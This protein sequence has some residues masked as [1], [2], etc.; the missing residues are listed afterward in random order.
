M[1][2]GIWF[3]RRWSHILLLKMVSYACLK[4]MKAVYS[5]DEPLCQKSLQSKP[6]VKMCD[7]LE[8]EKRNDA[9][10][11]IA[12]LNKSSRSNQASARISQPH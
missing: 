3:L 4:S 5:R 8:R 1:W 2:I 9:V 12:A 11:D 10:C 6:P 7:C